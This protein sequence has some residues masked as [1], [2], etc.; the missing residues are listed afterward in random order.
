M[1]WL[2]VFCTEGLYKEC[3]EGNLFWCCQ[4]F[5]DMFSRVLGHFL[6]TCSM[7]DSLYKRKTWMNQLNCSVLSP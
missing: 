7:V 6:D 2:L 1:L 3:W 5:C 4:V